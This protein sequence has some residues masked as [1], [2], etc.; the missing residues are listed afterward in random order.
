MT[1]EHLAYILEMMGRSQS[2]SWLPRRVPG[3]LTFKGKPNLIVC[4]TKQQVEIVLTIYANS[5]N[6]PL[7]AN[8]EVLFCHSKT[9]SEEVENFLRIA[10]KS[11]GDKI[12][13]LMNIQDIDYENTSRIERFLTS[14]HTAE[15][16]DNYVVVFICCNDKQEKTQQPSILSSLLVKNKVTA[17]S[18]STSDLE[19]Y[20]L[21]KLV[22]SQSDSLAVYDLNKSSC[23]ALLSKQAG[24]GKST[25]VDKFKNSIPEEFDFKLIRIK[26]NC[27]NL[28]DETQK[29]IE[30]VSLKDKKKKKTL[31]HIDI[32]N[33]VF[34]NINLYL[35]NL[36]VLGYIKHSNGLVYRR[37]SQDLFLIEMMSPCYPSSGGKSTN[38]FHSILNFIPRIEFRSPTKYLY[39][40]KNS[41]ELE[42]NQN[43]LVDNLF[44][45]YYQEAR[46][47]RSAYYLRLFKEDMNSLG[48][49]LFSKATQL[50]QIK[51][52]D[53][54]LSYVELNNPSWAE[55][56]NF[57]NFLDEQIDCIESCDSL[58][59]IIDLKTIC[60]RFVIMMA[61]DFGSPSLRIG[62]DAT[63]FNIRGE[64]ELEIDISKLELARK[65]ENS[66]HPYILFYERKQAFTL[67][68]I[69][70]DRRLYKFVN[71]NSNAIMADNEINIPSHLR[72]ELLRKEVPIFDNF[73]DF[74]RT[75]KI[76]LLRKVMGLDSHELN[77]LDPDPTY[78]LTVD[79]CLKLMA[80]F[81]RLRT[82]SPVI[83]MGETG[84]GKTRKIKFYSSLHYDAK[85]KKNADYKHLIHFKIHGGVTYQDIQDKV[86]EAERLSR[87]NFRKLYRNNST[88]RSAV[89][90]NGVPDIPATAILFFD[91]ANTTEAIGLIK[92][93]L[94]DQT[95]QGRQINFSYGL[96]IIAAINPYRRHT[97]EMITKLEEAGLG[98]FMSPN[99]SKEKFGHLPMRHLVYRV[100]PLPASLLPLIWDFGQLD[101]NTENIYICQMLSKS[102]KSLLNISDVEI[103]FYSRL[104]TKCQEFMR[105]QRD[106]C[107]FVSLRD[108]ERV[109][110]ITSWF[111][112]KK[113]I[114]L[115]RM[116]N[117]SNKVALVD[118]N[119]ADNI[120]DI[121]RSFNLALAVCYHSS[122][123]SQD[124]RFKFR[125]LI[126]SYLLPD[127]PYSVQNDWVL[128]EILLCQHI[129]L[130]EVHLASNIARNSALLE[131]VFMIIICLELRIPLFIVGKPGSS[132]SLAKSIVSNAM[133]GNNS[134]SE[135]F[136]NLKETYFVNFQCSPLTKPEMIIE[137]F[138]SAASFQENYS[139]DKYV[140][141]VNLD[142]IGLAEGSESMP[143]KTLHPLL[144]EGVETA[145]NKVKESNKVGFIGISN[146]ALDPAKMNR[147]IFVSRGEPDIS[148][149]IESA[150][151]ICN[152]NDHIYKSINPF[153]KEIAEAYLDLCEQAKRHRREFFGLRD[154][155]SLIKMLYWFCSRDAILTWSKLEHSVRR[156]FGGLDLECVEP[157]KRRLYSKLDTRQLDTDPKCSPIDLIYSALKGE[158][159]ESN[160]RYLLLLTENYSLL[161]M[162][163][164]Y[165]T[166]MLQIPSHKLSII[167]GS[168][169]RNDLQYTEVCRN[170]SRIKASME[171]G[172]TVIL[173]NL[174]N[175]YE[176]LYDTL[177]QYY[178]EF[179]GQRYVYLGLNTHRVEC[180]VH[181]DFRLIIVSDKETVY[182]LKRFPIP[183]INRLEKHFLTSAIMLNPTQTRIAAQV[184]NWVNAYC[185]SGIDAFRAKPKPSDIFIGYHEDTVPSILLYLA[186]GNA[187]TLEQMDDDT[188]YDEETLET[189]VKSFLLRCAT[190]DSIVRLTLNQNKSPAITE[191][192]WDEY[193]I[194]QN[195]SSLS[196]L[197]KGHLSEYSDKN[198]RNL[199]NFNI[200]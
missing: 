145:D 162:I 24:N 104:L 114:I 152:Y 86:A 4:T 89:E 100:Q 169:F 181:K 189:K 13:T 42:H 175:L 22:T 195:H 37:S 134:K 82:R 77:Y 137:A 112:S 99:E 68:G 62:S 91:E 49:F 110:K 194:N 105:E 56:A 78:E 179:A 157:F 61:Y 6:N 187:G 95:C 33:E 126:G 107:S 1:L 55:L 45:F 109:I 161:D 103:K 160:A 57:V 171:M 168:S 31:Y 88:I 122:L 46:F 81:M 30:Y 200:I 48:S 199:I 38:W 64:N 50:D 108:I 14:N 18:L 116:V 8:D 47:Q 119:Y 176:S 150:K 52:L 25:F 66:A 139:L 178:Y 155:Y 54:L 85:D 192:V 67:M 148:E 198:G 3:F 26:S 19:K 21:N 53:Q 34:Q 41:N 164:S 40:L 196:D 123:Q 93:I 163:Q 12:Y 43:L 118:Q 58:K 92:E 138:R 127:K 94:C 15:Q 27:I 166:Q 63:L 72:I 159:V 158:S 151:G 142:E 165:L 76:S 5:P 96:K 191:N 174:Q 97:D 59:K 147:G 87:E 69:Y 20:L 136:K 121:K 9:T 32:A 193:F 197:I 128:N 129:F 124:R 10:Y 172:N 90:T 185:K 149:L 120:D 75:R 102:V 115:N 170:I 167:F 173:L 35:F 154:F 60:A 28:D 71:P 190:A 44:N 83:I 74:P 146:W 11:N 17:L 23:R 141:V 133:H 132:K 177:N 182:D 113:E 73:N 184:A 80:I 98:F 144:E 153:I 2:K 106:E 125:K 7:P 135:L 51:C 70:L 140:S 130:D 156:N 65:W 117:K 183:L 16:T 29:L 101:E 143:L 186:K 39:D 188:E 111:I 36:V 79:N 180:A 131:N 84:C